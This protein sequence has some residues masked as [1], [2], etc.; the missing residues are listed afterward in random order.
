MENLTSRLTH[1]A[2]ILANVTKMI[3]LADDRELA[4]LAALVKGYV[5]QG[6]PLNYFVSPGYLELVAVNVLL[7]EGP[8]ISEDDVNA[9]Y[10]SLPI[11]VIEYL[12]DYENI[13]DEDL[14]EFN[15][16]R[17]VL[18]FA[19]FGE[20]EELDPTRETYEQ[21]SRT[22]S[23]S[24]RRALELAILFDDSAKQRKQV[25]GPPQ[26]MTPAERKQALT[27]NRESRKVIAGSREGEQKLIRDLDAEAREL[28]RLI[29]KDSRKRKPTPI[30]S[31]RK[32]TRKAA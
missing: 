1:T 5:Q 14:R 29:R 30:D 16:L 12:R 4:M 21:S 18:R 24:M 2:T 32:A 11:H 27:L 25:A 9:P 17:Q 3:D 8:E 7:K 19:R 13:D 26:E 22:K 10:N 31:K 20:P 23:C 15:I 6:G 28:R